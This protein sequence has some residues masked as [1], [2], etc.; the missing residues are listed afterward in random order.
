VIDEPAARNWIH[1]AQ[2]PVERIIVASAGQDSSRITRTVLQ[3]QQA[4][5][6]TDSLAATYAAVLGRISLAELDPGALFVQ[7]KMTPSQVAMQIQAVYSWVLALAAVVILSPLMLALAVLLRYRSSGPLLER[8]LCMGW[9]N[10]PFTR[11]R[12]RHDGLRR[13]RLRG[14]PQLFNVLKNEMSLVGPRP[15]RTEFAQ[16]LAASM[17]LFPYRHSVRPGIFG[18]EQLNH[19]PPGP[20]REVTKQFEF[21]LFYI[22]NFSPQ[23]DFYI[24]LHSLKVLFLQ[25]RSPLEG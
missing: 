15:L 19:L 9:N 10:I 12:F 11:Y 1:D 25:G 13:Y 14:L 7:G 2:S 17:P 21:E 4:G 8:Q 18:W 5:Y 20:V 3:V 23:L 22:Q 24:I 16:A 6:R